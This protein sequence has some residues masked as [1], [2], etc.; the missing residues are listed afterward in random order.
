M[1]NLNKICKEVLKKAEFAVIIT[2]NDK[3]PHVVGTW[4][5]Y[6]RALSII[7]EDLIVIPSGHYE[8]T[9]Y[10]LKKNKRIKLLVASK[11]IEG[12]YGPGQGC[13][14]EGEGEIQTKGKYAKKAK[15]KFNWARGALVIK[16]KE[17]KAQL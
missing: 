4:G 16:V 14:I 3:E 1:T 9:E 12:S 15:E 5:D 7:D 17:T 13:L 11:Q 6:I 2:W 10:N 8:R